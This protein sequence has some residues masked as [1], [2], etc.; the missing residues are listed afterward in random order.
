MQA[1]PDAPDVVSYD[2]QYPG[3]G[4]TMLG[5]V[6]YPRT[7]EPLYAPGVIV[8]HDNC[9]LVDHHRDVARR[10]ARAGFVAIAPDLP[11]RQGGTSKFT[12]PAQQSQAYG[13]TTRDERYSD[14]IATL[15]YLKTLPVTRHDRIG[16]VGFCAGGGNAWDFAINTEEIAA[17]VPFYGA[18]TPAPETLGK[19]NAA[20][21]TIYAEQDRALTGRMAPVMQAL[22]DQRKSFGFYVYEGAGHA[23]HN[24][25]GP[26]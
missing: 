12:D 3:D 2:V 1:P 7:A 19:L 25:T 26:A 4:T 11:S 16:V 14:L 22:L 20:V 18:P 23:F 6:S 15:S 8:I 24:D 13:R 5:Y 17:A 21:L 9:G 10:V